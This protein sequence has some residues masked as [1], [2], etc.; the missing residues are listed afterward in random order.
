MNFARALLFLAMPL[1]LGSCAGYR[2]GGAKPEAL[3]GIDSI[4][5]PL[6]KNETQIPRGAALTTNVVA[7]ALVLDGTYELGNADNAQAILE[8][9]FFTLDYNAIRTNR[10]DRLRPEELSMAVTLKWKVIAADNPLKILDSGTSTGRTT[11]F[12]DPNLQTAQQSSIFDA[13]QRA[14]TSLVARLADHF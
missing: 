6:A 10:F 13:L 14:A 8:V 4:H 2:L 11:F 1:A 7:D 5:V 3:R 12:V 9:R